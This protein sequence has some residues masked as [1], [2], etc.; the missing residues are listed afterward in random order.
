MKI[1]R[2]SF[3]RSFLYTGLGLGFFPRLMAQK[4]T[5]KNIPAKRVLGRTGIEVTSLGLGASRTQQSAVLKYAIDHGINF[6][7]TGRR[8]ANGRNEEMIGETLNGIRKD[9]V[10]QSKMKVSLKGKAGN[11]EKIREQMENSLQESLKA[12]QTE[13]IDIMLLHGIDQVEYLQNETIRQ[14]FNEMKLRGSIRACGFSSHTNMVN[15]MKMANKDHFFDVIMVPFNPFGAF[16]HSQSDWSTSWDQEA[17]VK[18]MKK[19][20]ANGTGI[21]PMKTCSG[22]PYAFNKDQETSYAGAVKWVRSHDF[23]A[24]T[25]VAMVN[26]EE[27]KEHTA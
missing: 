13:Y 26:F 4:A 25:A 2:K 15:L 8:Y 5:K 14:V 9:F 11:P 19:A 16:Q 12:L 24:T 22:G 23:V 1:T 21:V 20:H 6:L 7:D 17:L 27:I 18:E 10:I 3:I